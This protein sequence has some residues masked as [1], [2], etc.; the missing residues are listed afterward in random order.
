VID[1]LKFKQV[2]TIMKKLIKF[3]QITQT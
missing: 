1:K 3:L 2:R